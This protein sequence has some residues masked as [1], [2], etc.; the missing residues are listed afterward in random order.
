[1]LD[2]LTLKGCIE[3]AIKTEELGAKNYSR[4]AEKFGN[5]S[6]IAQLFT[7]LSEDELVHKQQF[8]ELLKKA[9]QSSTEDR[10]TETDD[11]LKAMS[12]TVYFSRLHGPFKDIDKIRDK[13]DA[14][15]KALEFEKA[16]LGFY[17]AVEEVQGGSEQLTRIIAAERSHLVVLMKAL[18]VEGSEFR[19]LQDTWP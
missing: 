1:M 11:Y 12:Q 5:I 19:S 9:P 3:F 7:R 13:E 18:L 8:S 2:D 16:T 15:L 4:L 10:N 6:D 14:L 17:K